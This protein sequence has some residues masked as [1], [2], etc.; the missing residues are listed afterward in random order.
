MESNTSRLATYQPPCNA[1]PVEAKVI[2]ES[3]M[4]ESTFSVGSNDEIG[5]NKNEEIVIPMNCDDSSLPVVVFEPVKQF[6]ISSSNGVYTT[7]DNNCNVKVGVLCE[8]NEDQ[9]IPNGGTNL[10]QGNNN[11]G[12]A[13][14]NGGTNIKT[15]EHIPN[16]DTVISSKKQSAD[17]NKIVP[18]TH[19]HSQ[20]WVAVKLPAVSSAGAAVKPAVYSSTLVKS[21][22]RVIETAEVQQVH[23]G[24]EE[25]P[26][27]SLSASQ[28]IEQPGLVWYKRYSRRQLLTLISLCLVD[29]TCFLGM[30]IMAP[31]F[32]M[33]AEAKNMDEATIGF[34][35]STYA[36]VMFLTSPIFGRI[37]PRV[38]ANFLFLSGLFLAGGCTVLFGVLDEID[39]EMFSVMCFVIRSFEALGA[40]AYNTASCTIVAEM[41]PDNIGAVFGILETFVGLGMTVGPALGAA[42]YALQGY[43]LPFLL[44]GGFM[45]LMVPLNMV[46]LPAQ[47]SGVQVKS[48]SIIQLLKLPTVVIMCVVVVVQASAWS[49]LDPFLEP[50]LRGNFSLSTETVGLVFLMMSATYGI[51]CPVWGWVADR[52]EHTSIMMF[53]GMIL[54]SIALL[55]LGPTELLPFI[56]N[57]LWLNMLSLILLGVA[58]A[59]AIIPTFQSMMDYAIDAGFEDGISTYSVVSGLWAA[60]YSLG[61]FVGPS[62]GGVLV[63]ASD[64]PTAA[65]GVAG[66]IIVGAVIL[67]LY[68]TILC[69]RQRLADNS[70]KL[71]EKTK[72][73]N[74]S[75]TTPLL[76]AVY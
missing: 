6:V 67:I 22:A 27:P 26:P 57:Y 8:L 47:I 49:F 55:L 58:M 59:L 44:L 43:K 65:T 51:F 74:D 46:L 45:I 54:S 75:E 31:F 36:L 16:H 62:L 52:W 38:G 48:G 1:V 53:C 68:E 40:A 18:K 28:E 14:C 61:D 71:P 35:F 3:T 10:S 15:D 20:P 76:K 70:T 12:E 13:V 4:E 23:G 17:K 2:I 11:S 64:F 24:D 60:S 50:Q 37:L 39:G 25:K 73:E 33:E 72:L 34:V 19:K 21:P 32:P 56:D 63:K 7:T 30:S 9:N 69:W 66:I 5:G 29:F 42:L 41:F